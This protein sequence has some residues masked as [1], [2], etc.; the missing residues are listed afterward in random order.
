MLKNSCLVSIVES[1][2]DLCLV[3]VKSLDY[4]IVDDC[5]YTDTNLQTQDEMLCSKTVNFYET[6]T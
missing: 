5:I 1:L 6:S 3:E 2:D 4:C